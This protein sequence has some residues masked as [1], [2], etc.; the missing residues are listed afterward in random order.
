MIHK[1][2]IRK[3][4][5]IELH[6]HLEGAFT[7]EVLLNL[8][9][10]YGGDSSIKNIRDL[11]KKFTFKDFPHF[12]ETWF[13]K[14]QFFKEAIDFERSTYHTLERLQ[15]Q[16]VIYA[17]VFYSPWDFIP[18][19]LT[20]QEITEATLTAIERAANDYGIKCG[21]IPDLCRDYG[22]QKAIDR[23]DEITPYLGKGIIGIGLG[24]SEQSFPAEPYARVYHIAKERG[25]HVT[26]HA[27]EAAGAAS[28]WA[29]IQKLGVERIGHGV[30]AIEDPKL[31]ATLQQNQ[32]PLEICITSNLK[33]GVFPSLAAHPIKYFVDNGLFVTINS[34]DPT[35]FGTD[36]S[37]E[38]LMLYEELHFSMDSIKQ[39]CLNAVAG[40][41]LPNTEKWMYKQQI[42][43]YWKPNG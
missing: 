11:Q 1:D 43:E 22:W 29:A 41:F 9:E 14:N 31:I 20:V 36:I 18:Q 38:F 15:Q 12:I 5:K 7:F 6:L 40:S 23:L 25:F 10:K 35:M 21:L 30:R 32:I 2:F 33:T 34:D 3:M 28:I 42:D 27:G 16:N 39:L 13:W 24:G 8:I 4:P 26:A 37:S 19:G 17:E